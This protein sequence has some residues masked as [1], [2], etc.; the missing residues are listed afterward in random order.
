MTAARLAP[1]PG[2]RASRV[3]REP[4][5][6]GRSRARSPA[7]AR[8]RPA[9]PS[10]RR[11][12]LDVSATSGR[13]AGEEHVRLVAVGAD[14]DEMGA[15]LVH[16]R[17][18]R[19]PARGG[20]RRAP[21][22]AR[23]GNR[24]ASD[25]LHRLPVPAAVDWRAPARA[26][27]RPP[28]HAR[29]RCRPGAARARCTPRIAADEEDDDHDDEG[30]IRTIAS[31]EMARGGVNMRASSLGSREAQ[32]RGPPRGTAPIKSAATYSPRPLRAQVPSALRGLTALFG[33]GRGVA[34]S[35]SPPK[36]RE[37]GAEG[38]PPAPELENCTVGRSPAPN[39]REPAEDQISVKPSNH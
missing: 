3:A 5:A 23:L 13:R 18:D 16:A 6:R 7:P 39:A 33:M 10:P 24:V 31:V 4:R 21:T 9:P 19:R 26:P 38:T 34:P 20:A 32:R 2:P 28:P 22:R 27:S 29:H 36:S 17:D 25:L 15:V 12:L 1:A 37:T 8:R 30:P 35:L 14:R 11:A